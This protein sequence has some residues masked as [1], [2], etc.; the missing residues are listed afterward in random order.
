MGRMSEL[1]ITIE[2]TICRITYSFNDAEKDIPKEFS[3]FTPLEGALVE[4]MK[5]DRHLHILTETA[6]PSSGI[7]P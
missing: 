2:E 6:P 5:S 4:V 7:V 1:H 3:K